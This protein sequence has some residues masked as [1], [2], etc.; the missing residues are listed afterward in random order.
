[1]FSLFHQLVGVQEQKTA[2][3]NGRLISPKG[4][5]FTVLPDAD[6]NVIIIIEPHLSQR[7]RFCVEVFLHLDTRLQRFH[8]ESQFPFLVLLL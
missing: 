5:V 3:K 1:M 7:E 4:V 2:Q 6:R 8:G